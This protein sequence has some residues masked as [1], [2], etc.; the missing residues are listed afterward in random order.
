[1]STIS[2]VNRSK[3]IREVM[4]G[5]NSIECAMQK[6]HRVQKCLEELWSTFYIIVQSV[7][8][9][10]CHFQF[11]LLI[12][13]I[14]KEHLTN[15]IVISNYNPFSTWLIFIYVGRILPDE[16]LQREDISRAKDCNRSSPYSIVGIVEAMKQSLA[17]VCSTWL[18][19]FM[20][21]V[22]KSAIT[23]YGNECARLGF[24]MRKTRNRIIQNE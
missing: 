10:W 4:L 17:A 9:Q 20:H 23:N 19:G 7:F 1:M 6:M 18:T 14:Y 13:Q 11:F 12:F 21:K 2:A 22:E 3:T 24:F 16:R 5:T 8:F 15:W